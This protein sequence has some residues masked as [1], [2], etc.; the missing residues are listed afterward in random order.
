MAKGSDLYGS[1]GS[2]PQT[3][4]VAGGEASYLSVKSS[5]AD[6]GS[7]LYSAQEKLGSVVQSAG[8]DILKEETVAADRAADARTSDRIANAWAPEA[9]RK[10]LAF[11]TLRGPDK[12]VGYQSYLADLNSYR[13]QML[14]ESKSDREREQLSK[15]LN[16]RISSEAESAG[17]ELDGEI[18]NYE[19]QSLA[20]HA[21]AEAQMVAGNYNNPAEVE[22]AQQRID[23]LVEMRAMNNGIDP[24]TE[25]GREKISVLQQQAQGD[26]AVGMVGRA[27]S[28]GDVTSAYDVYKR[29]LSKIPVH[30]QLLIDSTLGTESVRQNSTNYVNAMMSGTV[31]PPPVGAPAIEVQALVAQTAANASLDPN[32]A[33]TVARIESNFGQNTGT[34]G[35]LGQDKESAGAPLDVQAQTMVKNLAEAKAV[36]DKALGRE[37]AP[38][39][40]YAVYQ[41]GAGGG[42]ALFRAAQEDPNARAVDVLRPLY[43]NARIAESAVTGNGGNVTMTS[44]QFLESLK[45][46][47][48][49]NEKYARVN[50]EGSASIGQEMMAAYQTR[51]IATQPAPTPWQ[52]LQNLDKALMPEKEKI[53]NSRLPEEDKKRILSSIDMKR[54]LAASQAEADRKSVQDKVYRLQADKSFVSYDQAPIELRS[55]IETDFPEMIPDLRTAAA[56][57]RGNKADPVVTGGFEARIDTL[58]ISKGG[59]TKVND[60]LS[61]SESA[62]LQDEILAQVDAGT[63]SGESGRA[64]IKNLQVKM[65]AAGVADKGKIRSA[66][67]ENDHYANA[68]REFVDSGANVAEANAMFREYVKISDKVG[69]DTQKPQ[70]YWRPQRDE[71]KHAVNPKTLVSAIL[72]RQ[73]SGKYAGLTMLPEPPNAAVGNDGS[74]IVVSSTKPTTPADVK[75]KA[76][77]KVMVDAAG[78]RAR[79]YEDGR[80]E[81]IQ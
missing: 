60:D 25:E 59:K 9:A 35:T 66:L 10:R 18:K 24:Q 39:E 63:V 79:V 54:G 69:L 22:K 44:G 45:K 32:I 6:A 67:G 28:A 81:E 36:A 75:I 7:Q 71:E 4:P 64:M 26:V 76:G 70:E 74:N 77:F 1:M 40:Q 12:V 15:Y 34:R 20:D 3:S 58:F 27:L 41:Q 62:R 38:W 19:D 23:A 42:P 72:A 31:P 47:Y 13:E 37:A 30:K 48:E 56:T 8:V 65:A 29:N 50:T 43:P 53:V 5:P 16:D 46:K 68:F 78:N 21:F 11:Q 49:I 17:R 33:L 52:Y 73:A 2:V 80:I 61:I 51:P 57:N 55:R 14:S